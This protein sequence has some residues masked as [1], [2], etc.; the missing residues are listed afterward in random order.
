MRP[1][2]PVHDVCTIASAA[3]AP[4]TGGIDIA[5]TIDRGA[6]AVDVAV[7]TA[8]LEESSEMADH[9]GVSKVV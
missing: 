2:Q 7:V 8:T 1:T 3:L 4:A 5:G 9:E 6:S